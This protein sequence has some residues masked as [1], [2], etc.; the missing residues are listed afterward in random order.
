MSSAAAATEGLLRLLASLTASLEGRFRLTAAE[1][2]L[3]ATS[4]IVSSRGPMSSGT[5]VLAHSV[6]TFSFAAHSPLSAIP[7][8]DDEQ[9][10][11]IGY[12]EGNF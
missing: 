11:K 3:G 4:G 5:V 6:V 12:R 9:S 2:D 1:D 8:S 7:L 10:G